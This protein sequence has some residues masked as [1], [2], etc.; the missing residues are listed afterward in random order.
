MEGVDPTFD[1]SAW[2]DYA[3][4]PLIEN[5]LRKLNF[6]KPSPIQEKALPLGLAGRDVV[7]V[8]ETVS[9][10]LHCCTL[11]RLRA[12]MFLFESVDMTTEFRNTI[13]TGFR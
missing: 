12:L 5:A 3:F 13:S 9:R 2:K 10:Q 1:V 4:S 8:A 11:D 7:G 6:T